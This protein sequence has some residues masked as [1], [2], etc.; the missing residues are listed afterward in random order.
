MCNEN[1]LGKNPFYWE[2]PP[3]PLVDLRSERNRLYRGTL[4]LD[5]DGTLTRPG[6]D[7]AIDPSVVKVLAEFRRGGGNIIFCT[8]A[9]TGRME[10]TLL[11]DLY[12]EIDTTDGD[13]VDETAVDCIRGT[14]LLP[15]NG[16]AILMLVDVDV[17]ENEL[18]FGWRRFRERRIPGEERLRAI[19]EREIVPQYPG[20]F[21]AGT[22]PDDKPRREYMLSLK[23]LPRGTTLGIKSRIEEGLVP[24]HREI[25]WKKIAIKAARTTIDFVNSDSG[26]VP[27]IQW[28]LTEVSGLHGPVFG[29]GDL[30]DEFASVVPTFNVNTQDPNSF[31]RRGMPAMDLTGGWQLLDESSYVIAGEGGNAVVHG[32]SS[33]KQIKVVRGEDGGIIYAQDCEG[34]LVPTTREKGRPLLIKPL[35]NPGNT[36][37]VIR[38]AGKGTAWTI[39][40]MMENGMFK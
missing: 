18:A 36:S 11:T 14:L 13:A 26:K 16:S 28:V 5:N 38:G 33:G 23:G 6:S 22:R 40:Y 25:E 34:R 8:G 27:S 2:I 37:E 10:R 3:S 15:E 24:S 32:Q 1:S 39:R 7:Y 35:T 31:R 4:I 19:L 12:R 9:T 21:L 20:S 30:G 29:F 17:Y